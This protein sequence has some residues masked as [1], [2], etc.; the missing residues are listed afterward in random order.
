MHAERGESADLATALIRLCFVVQRVYGEASRRYGLTPQHAQLLGVLAGGP[1]GMA[2]LGEA[3]RLEKSSL[4]GLIDRAEARELVARVRDT[5]DRRTCQVSLT[6]SGRDLATRFRDYVSG[7]LNAL[8]ADLP[9]RTSRQLTAAMWEI[10]GAHDVSAIFGCAA[11][12]LPEA[13]AG[14]RARSFGVETLG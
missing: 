6:E 14:E 10:V 11:P 3:L 8:A 4:S 12:S 5:N 2:E 7:E 9:D 1:V 13:P